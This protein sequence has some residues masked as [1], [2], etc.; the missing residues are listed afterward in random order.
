MLS[1][2]RLTTLP[3]IL[4]TAINTSTTSLS[5]L[6]HRPLVP[7]ALG[8]KV[9][10]SL[11][12]SP[13]PQDLTLTLPK[14]SFE[15]YR[16]EPPSLEVNI[17]KED[18]MWMHKS[19][20]TMRRMETTADTLYK[21]QLIRGFCHLCTGQEA[22]GVGLESALT[23]EDKVITAYR[24]HG[25]TYMRNGSILPVLAELLGRK[26]GISGGKGGSMHMFTPNF[27]GG[28]GIVGA[29]VPLGA[30]IA[31]AQKYLGK[32]AATFVFYGDG[33]ANQGQVFEAFNMAKLWE[34]PAV[35]V[36]ENNRYGMGTPA[37]RASAST[38]YYK[39]GDY[40]PGI[41]V[42]GMDVLAVHQ[43]V[44]Y[45]RDWTLIDQKGPLLLE[46]VTYRYGGHSM[47]DPGVSYRSREEIQKMRSDNDPITNLKE[48]LLENKVVS[49]E[50]LKAIEKTARAEVDNATNEAKAS[51]EPDM[52]A[53]WT[54][55]YVKGHEVPYL[56][57]REPE[58][59]HYYRK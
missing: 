28:N 17:K 29:Q 9:T 44:S 59:T 43:A 52:D 33:A 56:R 50:E 48:R 4:P 47:S 31:F 23:Q 38:E 1:S 58:E 8:Y 53:V 25:I 15:S 22:V 24:S 51:P 39:R 46:M 55:V 5:A 26:N 13:T 16:C 20:V 36:C 30:G 3:R 2:A 18:L 41:K 21:S 37:E 10:R 35:F 7:L 54:N 42:D 6:P 40:I 11:A 14:D 32:K 45:A 34:L 57:G 19:M 49:E 12:S 27:F